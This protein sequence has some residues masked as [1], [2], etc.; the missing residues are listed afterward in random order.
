MRL[1]NKF[2]AW[3]FGYFWLPCPI[4]GKYFGGHETANIFTAG[5]VA[6]DGH[7]YGVCPDP[8]CSYE[9]GILNAANGHLCLIRVNQK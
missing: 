4:C 7:A 8:Q 9:A 6:E 5:L 2:Y 1:L 3:A